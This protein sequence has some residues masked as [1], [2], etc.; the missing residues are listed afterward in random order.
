MRS[1]SDTRCPNRESPR[2][3]RCSFPSWGRVE[4]RVQ[5]EQFRGAR[6]GNSAR[7]DLCGGRPATGVPTAIP[8]VE[9][10]AVEIRHV[11]SGVPLDGDEATLIMSPNGSCA[12][13][14]RW[15]QGIRQSRVVHCISAAEAVVSAKAR[16]LID[17]ALP[18]GP[19]EHAASLRYRSSVL[20]DGRTEIRPHWM[21]KISGRPN[22][23]VDAVQP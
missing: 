21:L 23:H 18:T 17:T 5:S 8:D 3:G 13:R 1:S 15:T 4:D 12:C 22:V 9:S 11:L 10:H 16:G 14:V 2:A 19:I 20:P 7:R 6:C